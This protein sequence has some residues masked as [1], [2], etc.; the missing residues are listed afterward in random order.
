[1]PVSALK[2][3]SSAARTSLA[4]L[5]GI[6]SRGVW[7]TLADDGAAR[8]REK[9]WDDHAIG[10]DLLFIDLHLVHEVSSPQ[11]FE[12]LRAAGRTVRRVDRTLATADHNV[13]DDRDLS[14]PIAD[15]LSQAQLDALTANVA[16]FGIPFYGLGHARQG[17]VH[18]IGP[19][20]GH[21]AAR[22]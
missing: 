7:E 2:I 21:D 1:M 10:N 9:I 3:F 18:V 20:L 22:A 11:A 13:P 8:W 15:P 4:S 14:R 17:I 16:E 12:G 6:L 5:I 19:E